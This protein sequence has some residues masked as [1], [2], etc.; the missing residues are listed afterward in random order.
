MANVLHFRDDIAG[1][2]AV[3]APNSS[4]E[5]ML[6]QGSEMIGGAIYTQV[7]FIWLYE[8]L[9]FGKAASFTAVDALNKTTIPALIIHGTRDSTVKFD[10][11]GIMGHRHQITN[12]NVQFIV[13]DEE[14]R[15]GHN[16]I[17]RS[18]DS[19]HYTNQL[20]AELK[21]LSSQYNGGIPSERKKEFFA[22]ID[23]A[24]ANEVNRELMDTIH[25]FFLSCL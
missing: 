17:L 16:N 3:A 18:L 14:E 12:P 6:E 19:I 8:R 4:M 15:S 20:N 5:I 25:R 13:L 22:R 10:G 7:P 11:S 24:A 23:K 9:V 21:A 1:L 2:A